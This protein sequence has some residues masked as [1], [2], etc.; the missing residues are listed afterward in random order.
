MLADALQKGEKEEP[1][2]HYK[3]DEKQ[4]SVLMTEEGYE[5]AEEVLGV[6]VPSR[7]SN[8][9]SWIIQVRDGA[10]Y[11]TLS[12]AAFAKILFILPILVSLHS[13]RT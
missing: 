12:G 8:L 11:M 7:L 13:H 1:G 10:G 9:F 5:V 4:K 3:V 6:S 2:V